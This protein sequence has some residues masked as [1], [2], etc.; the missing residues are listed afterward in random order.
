[1]SKSKPP[2]GGKTNGLGPA[3]ANVSGS[4]PQSRRDTGAS[5]SAASLRHAQSST[6]KTPVSSSSSSNGSDNQPRV[7]GKGQRAHEQS[8][9]TFD[10]SKEWD[11]ISEIIA[12]ISSGLSDKGDSIAHGYDHAGQSAYKY[13]FHYSCIPVLIS[14]HND[15]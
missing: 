6:D 8:Q 13:R 14:Y 2:A 4:S 11:K 9:Q 7:H 15:I 10:E 1:M 3:D 12:S 5:N